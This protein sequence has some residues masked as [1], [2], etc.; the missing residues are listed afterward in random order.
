[1]RSLSCVRRVVLVNSRGR[2][3]QVVS[4]MK[5]DVIDELVEALKGR[6]RGI[7]ADGVGDFSELNGIHGALERLREFRDK[8][9]KRSVEIR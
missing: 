8:I 2:N 3:V 9:L 7:I 1:M 6:Q 5:V 4:S